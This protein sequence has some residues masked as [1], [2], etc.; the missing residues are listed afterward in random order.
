MRK[1]IQYFYKLCLVLIVIGLINIWCICWPIS[2]Q[3]INDNARNKQVIN[4]IKLETEKLL[5]PIPKQQQNCLKKQKYCKMGN[6]IFPFYRA[7]NYLF[8]SDF[9][10]DSRLNKF[11]NAKTKTWLSGDLHVDNFGTFDNDEGEVIFDLNDFDES[12]IADYQ[13]DLWRLA[14]SIILAS[15]ENNLLDQSQQAEVI[16]NLSESYLDTLASYTG[17]DDE[18]KIY[19]TNSNTNKHLKKL[20]KKAQEKTRQ[21]LLNKWTKIDQNNQRKFDLSSEKLAL[22][23]AIKEQIKY[24]ILVYSQPIAKKLDYQNNF[25]QV[26]DIARRLNA[27]LGSLGTPRYSVLIEGKTDQLDDDLIL[28]IKRQ[29]KPI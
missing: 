10:Q 3:P 12:V 27:G 22:P 21:D 2:A 17:N 15:N 8:W 7:T 9:F 16:D 18:K 24:Q 1:N 23:C 29:S 11:G 25:F 6:S 14:T 26:K 13:Y 28:D 5:Q 20:L 19:F 4:S